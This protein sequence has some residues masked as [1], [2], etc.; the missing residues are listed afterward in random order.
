MG[1]IE[2]LIGDE[3]HSL[4][5]I[6]GRQL[7][8]GGRLNRMMFRWYPPAKR[9]HVLARFYQR[10]PALI[11]RFYALELTAMDRARMFMGRPPKGLSLRAAL[12]GAI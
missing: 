7:A 3:L 12:G 6:H 5:R 2:A 8:F 10:S 4:A 1:I 11:E 9:H